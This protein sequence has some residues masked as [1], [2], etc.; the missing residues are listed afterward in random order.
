MNRIPATVATAA[1]LLSLVPSA[2][3]ATTPAATP[4]AIAWSVEPGGDDGR[5]NYDFALDPGAQ[6]RDSIVVRNTGSAPLE[7]DV[8][9]ADAFTTPEGV[10]DVRLA[11]E[12]RDGSGG[13]IALDTSALTLQPGDSAEVPFTL[14]VPGDATPGDHPAGIV[15]SL[16]TEAQGEVLGVDRRLGIRLQVRVAGD[17][18]PRVAVEKAT[19]SYAPSWN[20][21]EGGTAQ[22]SYT[23]RNT[24]NTR[25][26]ATDAVALTGPL[27][28]GGAGS[29][30]A[31][32]PE[33]LPGSA[34]EVRREVADLAPLGWLG[35]A[36]TVAPSAVGVGAQP[37][38][39]VTVEVQTAAVSWTLAAVI[40]L[41]LG[42][43]MAGAVLIVRRGRSAAQSRSQP[44]VPHQG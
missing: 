27:G 23:L 34:I 25:I 37:L 21:F 43:V 31:A 32:T 28:L 10:I 3:H 11:D 39:P 12:P 44:Q 35:G 36:L 18:E 20:P 40:L 42:A 15:T 33:I 26:T 13:W 19:A 30:P 5:A 4:G 1:L 29:L 24:G 38:D 14:S 2:A 17:L 7:L 16:L 8:Y 9:A 6:V 22:I 41:V